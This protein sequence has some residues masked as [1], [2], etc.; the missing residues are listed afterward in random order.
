MSKTKLILAIK[1]VERLYMGYVEK[2]MTVKDKI[3]SNGLGAFL[4]EQYYKCQQDKFGFVD[5]PLDNGSIKM[6]KTTLLN[7]ETIQT[8]IYANEEQITKYL[9][10]V[11]EFY[12]SRWHDRSYTLSKSDFVLA[13]SAWQAEHS[14]GVCGGSG[15][16]GSWQ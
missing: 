6:K 5:I 15:S 1:Q 16:C 13:I 12:S 3:E 9:R 14:F 10:E 7:K 11:L 8:E 4:E 2:E